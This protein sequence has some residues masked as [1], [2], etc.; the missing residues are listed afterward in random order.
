[1]LLSS[2]RKE[3][4]SI[5]ARRRGE[6]LDSWR[7]AT[8]FAFILIHRSVFDARERRRASREPLQRSGIDSYQ[9]LANLDRL[10]LRSNLL[11]RVA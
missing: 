9:I 5:L 1:M 8:L 4:A 6:E 2:E 11:R 7:N 3:P 10:I